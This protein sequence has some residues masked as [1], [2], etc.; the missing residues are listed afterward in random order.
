MFGFGAMSDMIVSKFL[1]RLVWLAG[2]PV[3]Y[4]IHR[5]MDE[6]I[7]EAMSEKKLLAF[8]Y[9]GYNRIAEPHVYG[10]KSDQNGMLVFQIGG[11]S[12]TGNLDWK[13][14]YM[15]KMTNMKVLDKTFPGMRE[16]TGMH[17]SWDFYYF[18]V[19]W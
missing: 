10:R 11:Q 6:M 16:T 9:D 7:R 15:K 1:S 14:M 4:F 2:F 19:D 18:L 13:I 8:D 12:S 17:K 5:T 3:R